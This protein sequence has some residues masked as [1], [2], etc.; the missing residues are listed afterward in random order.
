MKVNWL[1]L[2]CT[3]LRQTLT[4]KGLTKTSEK[5]HLLQTFQM[6]HSSFWRFWDLTNKT[7]HTSSQ[8]VNMIMFCRASPWPIW[9]TV[10]HL[11]QQALNCSLRDGLYC[12]TA[13]CRG[14]EILCGE[15]AARKPSL[16]RL[17]QQ[18]GCLACAAL[19]ATVL[20]LLSLH[21][22]SSGVIMAA[23]Q[24]LMEVWWE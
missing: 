21:L 13:R 18:T 7:N 8:N 2:V 15:Q 17:V 23:G 14:G 9:T 12:E 5:S 19:S 1:K 3:H 4:H 20:L 16:S 6:L 22:L 10:C 24:A 11:S